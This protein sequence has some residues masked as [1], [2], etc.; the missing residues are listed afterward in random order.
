MRA[1]LDVVWENAVAE[2]DSIA[3]R[4]RRAIKVRFTKMISW[5]VYYR[6]QGIDHPKE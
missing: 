3:M 4:L 2:M 1:V 5:G 6:K